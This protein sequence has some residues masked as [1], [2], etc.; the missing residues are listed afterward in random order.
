MIFKYAEFKKFINHTK[1]FGKI[2]P[3]SEWDTPNAIILRHDVDFDIEAAYRL[4]MI[5]A[6]YN[7]RSTFFFLTTCHTY[8][9]LSLPNRIK[10]YEMVKLGFEIGLHF[11]PTIY[12]DA[13]AKQLEVLP[14]FHKKRE[15]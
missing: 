3:L 1:N 4:A 7:I 9:L 11:D 13:T 6:E 8:N 5:E 14:G 10:L 2:V 12:S 15:V